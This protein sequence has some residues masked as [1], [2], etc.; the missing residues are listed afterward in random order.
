MEAIELE[1]S[2]RQLDTLARDEYHE[3]LEEVTTRSGESDE[4]RL[5]RIG[6]L[7]GVTLKQP[8]A[9]SKDLE[10][11]SN[12]TRA[13]RAWTLKSEAAFNNPQTQTSW[14]YQALEALRTDSNVIQSLGGPIP[15]V[16]MFAALAQGERGYFWYLAMSCREYLCRDPN[17]RNQIEREFETAKR[18]G[19]DLKNA[20]P[21]IIVASG[22]VTIGTALVQN[23]PTLGMMGVPVIAGLVYIV[24]SIGIDAFCRWTH[25]HEFY[26]PKFP[27][28][29]QD[30]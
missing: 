24:Y 8:F 18:A 6:R 7:L 10:R 22:G 4:Y 19:L 26:H 9:T 29:D 13:Y 28:S 14:Q 25:D 11:P 12:Y 16:Y 30:E 3:S 1:A 27:N 2:L 5:L 21:E 17:F 15:N 23:I 20:T